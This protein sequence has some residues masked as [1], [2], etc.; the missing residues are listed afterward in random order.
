MRTEQE[1]DGHR[2]A[3]QQTDAAGASHNTMPRLNA[4]QAGHPQHIV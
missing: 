1:T 2:D 4:L 3:A